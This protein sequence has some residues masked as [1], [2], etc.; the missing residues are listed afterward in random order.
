LCR[1]PSHTFHK[2][3]PCNV[4]VFLPLNTA[5]LDAVEH[6][7]RDG[8]NTI[9]KQYFTYLYSP[10]REVAFT[11]R[12][13]LAGWSIDGLVLLNPQRVLKYLE[14]PPAEPLDTDGGSALIPR[15]VPHEIPVVAVAP[16]TAEAFTS[17]HDFILER[18][19]HA[20]DYTERQSTTSAEADQGCPVLLSRACASGGTD[21]V[22]AHG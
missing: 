17:P 3:Q 22:L 8:V 7:E 5:Y 2:L 19:A 20:L 18:D 13:I 4:A 10:T 1:L 14:K 21:L 12:N 16:V 15:G 11:K 9:G 6:L